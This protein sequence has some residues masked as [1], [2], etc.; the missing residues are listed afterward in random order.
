VDFAAREE[1]PLSTGWSN[2]DTA[3][4]S[5]D[6]LRH[7]FDICIEARRAHEDDWPAIQRFITKRL[8]ALP[9]RQRDALKAMI[10]RALQ[11]GAPT[12]S[13]ILQ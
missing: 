3:S 8:S 13:N 12:A 2:L 9:A 5:D 1:L 4:P 10:D 11:F 6:E 7:L